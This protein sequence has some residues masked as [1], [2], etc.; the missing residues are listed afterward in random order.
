MLDKVTA[1]E[2]ILGTW[3]FAF[4][5]YFDFSAYSDIAI[6][7]ARMM[8]IHI[9]ENFQHPY[10]SRTVAEFWRRWHISLSTWLR[11]YLYIP[12]GGSRKVLARTI[13][14][15]LIVF[16]LGGLWHGADAKFIVWGLWIG[17]MIGLYNL[18]ATAFNYKND[19]DRSFIVRDLFG[20]IITFQLIAISWVFFRADSVDVALTMLQHLF[21]AERWIPAEVLNPNEWGAAVRIFA[22]VVL[23]HFARGLRYDRLLLQVRRPELIG[24]FWAVL[25]VVIMVFHADLTEQFIYFQF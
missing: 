22:F 21:V 23:M 5:I 14:N 20:I 6:G 8:G 24:V 15:V 7:I 19:Y 25:I 10:L 12:L 1:P 18:L 17:V 16:F 3:L 2:I 11:D 13:L 9:N 4:Q